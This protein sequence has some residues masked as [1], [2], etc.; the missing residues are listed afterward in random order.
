MIWEKQRYS[1]NEVDKAGEILKNKNSSEDDINRATKILNNWR[2]IHSYPLFIIKK[3]LGRASK[4]GDKKS[5]AFQRLK[6]ANSII[7]KLTRMSEGSSGTTPGLNKPYK[8]RNHN[9]NLSEMQDIAGCRAIVKNTETAKKIYKNH[10][11]KGNL[12]HV[13]VRKRT[14]DYIASP[15]KDGYRSIHLVYEYKSDKGKK[16]YN[17]LRVE[18]QIRSELQHL[19]A[20]AVET[21][22]LFTRQAIKFNEGKKDWTNFFRLVSSAFAIKEK[23]P[24]I[25]NTPEDKKELYSQIKKN[26]KSLKVIDRMEGWNA[27]MELFDKQAKKN[28]RRFFLTGT[29]CCG[30]RIAD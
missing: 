5:L 21:T 11:L 7:G 29:G 1:K 18:I 24:V 9:L 15:K 14:R 17:G 3:N 2:A 30:N 13:L 28:K 19:W 27:A 26:E 16:E 23:C 6:R 8:G 22:D 4:K 12:K 10:Y 20:T 25:E